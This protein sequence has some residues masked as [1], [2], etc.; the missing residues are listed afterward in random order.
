M[1]AGFCKRGR[2]TGHRA[3]CPPG[4]RT[5]APAPA[6]RKRREKTPDERAAI[7][8]RM[9]AYWKGASPVQGRRL[10][11]DRHREPGP[12]PIIADH[13]ARLSEGRRADAET[14]TRGTWWRMQRRS[15]V[16]EDTTTRQRREPGRRRAGPRHRRTGR[17]PARGG[18]RVPRRSGR[19]R[20]DGLRPLLR[21]LPRNDAAGRG[22][23]A[24]S[25]RSE[26]SEQLGIADRGGAVRVRA[27]RD[28]AGARRIAPERNLP[29]HRRL[30][31]AGERPCGGTAGAHRGRRGHRRRARRRS[32]KGRPRHGGCV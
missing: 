8:N 21:L 11:E 7:S 12:R 19:K 3:T 14:D 25:D 10:L 9:T 4:D 1:H 2:P 6:V 18:R 30:P 32:A 29:E 28:A 23:R 15:G 22:A 17:G 24:G 13:T 20:T 16:A 5:A 27:G 31:A 26:L